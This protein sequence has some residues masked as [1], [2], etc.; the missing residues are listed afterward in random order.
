MTATARP[1]V[2]ARAVKPRNMEHLEV[3]ADL[4]HE[5]APDGER[6]PRRDYRQVRAHGGPPA[7]R[8]Q[9]CDRPGDL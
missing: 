2:E 9:V 6:A 5:H 1:Y 7:R 3:L 4:V 8:R